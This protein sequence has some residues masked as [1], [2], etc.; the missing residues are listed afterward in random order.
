MKRYAIPVLFLL[1][2]L[3]FSR[4]ALFFDDPS[5]LLQAKSNVQ[6]FLR[7]YDFFM[8]LGGDPVPA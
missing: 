5:V 2:L 7:P 3:P 1:C 6:N 8:D 4:R